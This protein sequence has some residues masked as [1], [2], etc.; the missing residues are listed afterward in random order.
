MNTVNIPSPLPDILGALRNEP[1]EGN[2]PEI[3][4][5]SPTLICVSVTK[6]RSNPLE[7]KIIY[8]EALFAKDHAFVRAIFI[9]AGAWVEVVGEAQVNGSKFKKF[10]P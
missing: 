1:S 7:E 8:N 2:S 5:D 3:M 6:R 9:G 10:I 4:L